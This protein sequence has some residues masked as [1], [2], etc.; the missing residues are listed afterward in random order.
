MSLL[1]WMTLMLFAT[2][3]MPVAASAALLEDQVKAAYVAWDATFGKGDAKA[4]AAFYTDDA[5]LLPPNHEIIKSPAEI[6]KFFSGHFANGVTAHK[7]ELIEAMG[8][9]NMVVMAAKWPA[10]GKGAALGGIVTH[11][12]T[13]RAN[14]SFKIKLHTFN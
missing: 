4:I 13:K 9:T 12:F 10:K 2:L 11:V 6:E 1:R 14:G 8:D 5:I 7:L 3:L